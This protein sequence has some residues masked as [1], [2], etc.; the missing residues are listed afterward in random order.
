MSSEMGDDRAS[1]ISLVSV[2]LALLEACCC[3]QPEHGLCH[4][5]ELLTC[6]S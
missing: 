1:E 3:W 2:L 5:A 4:A 6:E